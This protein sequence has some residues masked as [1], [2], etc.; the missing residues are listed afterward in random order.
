MAA[1]DAVDRSSFEA[2]HTLL[3]T[4]RDLARTLADDPQIERLVRAFRM[5]PPRDREPILQVIEKDAAWRRIV[6]D[7][8]EATGIAVRANPH[9]SLYVHVLNQAEPP[10]RPDIAERD[11][12]VIRRGL[13]TFVA[14][15][16][17]LFQEGVHAQWTAAARDIIQASE[18][19]LLSLTS[20]LLREVETLLAERAAP[21]AP[22]AADARLRNPRAS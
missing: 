19:E 2:L 12:G 17:L 3:T 10:L 15:I 8:D 20:R 1:D 5:L 18:D 9:A 7:T 14:L 6:Q 4:A 16:P 21:A 22:Q 13:E 11:A